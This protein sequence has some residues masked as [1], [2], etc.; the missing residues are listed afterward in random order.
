MPGES[1]EI[2]SGFFHGGV[3]S[4][5]TVNR[6]RERL[7]VCHIPLWPSIDQDKQRDQQI[8][9]RLE[10]IEDKLDR[11]LN[12]MTWG[13]PCHKCHRDTFLLNGQFVCLI[14]GAIK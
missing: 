3:I 2:K 12:P 14:C 11:L 4:E 10:R 6:M 8:E 5:E 9:A 1:S 13:K 7:N